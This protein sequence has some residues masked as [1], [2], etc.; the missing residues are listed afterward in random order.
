MA[1]AEQGQVRQRGGA[2]L[3]PVTDVMALA[4]AD[5]AAG[6]AAAAVAMLK[7]SPQRRG[8][9]PR[10]GRDFHD[11]A[12]ARVLHH[13]AARVTRQAPGRFR[14]NVGAVVEDGL[15]G[16]IGIGESGS[17]DV[18]HHLIALAGRS[19]IDAVVKGRLRE[20]RERVSLLLGERRRFRG[21]V[22]GCW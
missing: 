20:Q 21:N 13:D 19:R 6:E 2:A 22:P 14:R 7:S 15:A 4:E 10:S 11:A 8:N 1:A 18:H 5:V 12:V 16:L 9:R 3:G 17:V